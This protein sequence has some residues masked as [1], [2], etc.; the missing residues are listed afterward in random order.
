[1]KPEK[2]ARAFLYTVYLIF[3]VAAGIL[4]A[5]FALI[6]FYNWTPPGFFV[7]AFAV[8]I[9][10]PIGLL[11]VWTKNIFGLRTGIIERT[12]VNDEDINEYMKKLISSGST[13]DIVSNRLHWVS[14]DESIKQKLIERVRSADIN[15]YLPVENQIARELR[16]N[17]LRIHIVQSLGTAPHARFTLVDKNRPG[18]AMLAVGAG[19]IPKFTISEFYEDTHPQVVAIARDYIKSLIEEAQSV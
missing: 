10:E 2:I 15:I 13:L 19:R 4:L 12:Y 6:I 14:E 17:G 16:E 1:L 18:S 5:G 11:I 7:Y 8:V 9:V 3:V